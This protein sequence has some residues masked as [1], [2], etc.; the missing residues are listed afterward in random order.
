MTHDVHRRL[1]LVALL[2]C[3]LALRPVHAQSDADDDAAQ[4]KVEIKI[5]RSASRAFERHYRVTS[6]GADVE[7]LRRILRKLVPYSGRA[8]PY[9]VKIAEIHQFNAITFPGGGIYVF[10]GLLEQKMSDDEVACVLAHEVIHAA[11][12]HS[13]RELLQMQALG[14]I[15]GGEGGLVSGLSAVLLQHGVGRTYENQADRLGLHVAAR[16]GYD[17]RAMLRVLHLIQ[18]LYKEHPGLLSGLLSTHPPTAERI[19]KVSA[20]L[21]A[22][23]R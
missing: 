9:T 19:K 13:Y 4:A 23:G 7:R 15:M 2:L 16:A 20:E 12:S 6:R 1:A 14:A 3:G 5:G 22:M 10:R 17:P 11:R 18:T 21:K 8:L